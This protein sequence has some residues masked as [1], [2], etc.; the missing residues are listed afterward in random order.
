MYLHEPVDGRTGGLRHSPHN[1]CVGLMLR[2]FQDVALEQFGGVQDAG[3]ILKPCTCGRNQSSGQGC[4][5]SG[6]RVALENQHLRTP[7]PG[8][9]RSSE[10]TGTRADDHNLGAD[11]WAR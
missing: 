8:R 11:F 4:A 6:A 9:Q 5:A 3:C 10:P 7:L 1:R 2:F